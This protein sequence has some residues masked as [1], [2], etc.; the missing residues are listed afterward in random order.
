MQLSGV[1]PQLKDKAVA[2]LSEA[3]AL[4][5]KGLMEGSPG[6]QQSVEGPCHLPALQCCPQVPQ[7]QVGRDSGDGY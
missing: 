7:Q 4:T 1:E 3:S 6:K 2:L 5:V